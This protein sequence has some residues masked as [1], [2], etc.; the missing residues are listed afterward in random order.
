[1]QFLLHEVEVN[2]TTLRQARP[3]PILDHHH[4][5]MGARE[6]RSVQTG[7][8]NFSGD[9]E[10]DIVDYAAESKDGGFT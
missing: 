10:S 1:M 7:D 3:S 9:E 4:H 2:Q 8:G 5:E 6:P